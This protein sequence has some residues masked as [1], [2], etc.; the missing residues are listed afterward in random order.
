[1]KFLITFI[2]LM[3]TGNLFSQDLPKQMTPE[4]QLIWNSY[5]QQIFETDDPNPPPTPVRTMAE[6]EEL[7]GIVITWTSYQSILRQIVQHA[8]QEG[9]V[10]I[11]CSDSN[12]VKTYLT[13]GGVPHINLKFVIAPFNSVWIRDYGPWTAYSGVADS[14][15]II[16]WIYN[17]PRLLDNQIPNVM[18][19]YL[20][21]PIYQMIQ[22][23]NNL[24]ATGGNFMVDGNHIGFSSKLILTENPGK[25]S[26]QIDAIMNAYMGLNTYIKMDVLPQDGIHHI[27]MH[28]KLLDEE[29]ILIGQYPPGNP[30]GPVVENNIQYILNNFLTCYGRPYKIVRIP[31]PQNLSGSPYYTYANSTFVNK[32]VIVPIYGFSQDTTALRIY[33]E[34]L[35]GYNVV[36]VLCNS[37]ISAGGAIHCINK[38]IGV[39]EPIFF[40][41]A[42]LLNTNNVSSPYNVKSYIKTRSG[43]AS[44]SLYWST[45]TTAGYNTVNMTAVGDTFTANIPAQPLGTN[46]YYYLSATSNSSRTVTK[47]LTAPTGH[48]KFLVDNETSI[49]GNNGEVLS[50]KLNQNY[51]NPF[52]PTTKINFEIPVSEFVTLKVYDISGRLVRSIYN[53]QFMT[54]GSYEVDFDAG[55]LSS[56]VYFYKLYTGKFYDVKKMILL[57]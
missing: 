32:T 31:M 56:G 29:T 38:E 40:S 53:N 8:Q 33:R 34:N 47:P 13:Q 30:D 3:F 25:T 55:D 36:G 49:S 50:Y 28:M 12:T 14:L 22:S 16:D 37:M 39:D 23:P 20:S 46:V 15:K 41:H 26:S 7:Q 43:V 11:V 19:N 57:K 4:E 24:I 17:R 1:M 18:A 48:Y 9:L 44:A 27:D 21:L 2:L 54:P 10:Y 35:P 51:P 5:R 42:K 6:W 45:D 52:N